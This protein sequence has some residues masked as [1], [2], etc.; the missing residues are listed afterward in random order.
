MCDVCQ[1][2]YLRPPLGL[3]PA[4][5]SDAHCQSDQDTLNINIYS[6]I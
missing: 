6:K 5:N 1:Y 2:L 3:D 4:D